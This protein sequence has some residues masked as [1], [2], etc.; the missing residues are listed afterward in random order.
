M[1]GVDLDDEGLNTF[2]NILL[3]KSGREIPPRAGSQQ[4][5]SV[6]CDSYQVPVMTNGESVCNWE[7]TPTRNRLP[8]I[9]RETILGG[10]V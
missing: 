10:I 1:K 7:T 5:S 8:T 9:L 4:R 3:S 6:T 2:R